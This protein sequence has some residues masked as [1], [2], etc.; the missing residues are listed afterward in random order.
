[1][2]SLK[3]KGT[4]NFKEFSERKGGEYKLEIMIGPS[5]ILIEDLIYITKSSGKKMKIYFEK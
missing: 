3:N 4:L 1:L 2:S 5:R